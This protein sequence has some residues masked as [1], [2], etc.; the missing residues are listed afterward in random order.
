VPI[1]RSPRTDIPHPGGPPVT[2]F[3]T[4][5]RSTGPQA[6]TSKTVVI[7]RY[8]A[9][10]LPDV[11]PMNEIHPIRPATPASTPASSIQSATEKSS[12]IKTKVPSTS[13]VSARTTNTPSKRA[14]SSGLASI[15]PSKNFA[16]SP[17]PNSTTSNALSP[18]KSADAP[19][20][21]RRACYDLVSIVCTALAAR[22]LPRAVR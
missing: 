5:Q 22:G 18:P 1:T 12:A 3:P 21:K 11:P 7:K 9:L 15:V 13:S 8:W 19:N 16:T 17:K 6:A 4:H 2:I 20:E 10:H 14:A